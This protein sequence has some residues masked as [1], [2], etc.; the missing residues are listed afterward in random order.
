MTA[1][2]LTLDSIDAALNSMENNML[3]SPDELDDCSILVSSSQYIDLQL[4]H[5]FFARLRRRFFGLNM[6]EV[7]I[8][9]LAYMPPSKED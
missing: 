6:E 3:L 8:V 2:K 5:S 9:V 4:D 1:D 7:K